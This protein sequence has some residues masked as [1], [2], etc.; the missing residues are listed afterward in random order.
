MDTNTKPTT[1]GAGVYIACL[2]KIF[3]MNFYK[4]DEGKIERKG[5]TLRVNLVG[6]K[7]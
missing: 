3:Y 6:K 4:P 7:L 2:H 1:F 5:G